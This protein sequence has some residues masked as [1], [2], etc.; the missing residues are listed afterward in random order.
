MLQQTQVD[1]VVPRWKRFMARFPDPAAA[2]SAGVAAVL[3]EWAGLG[4]NR[5]AVALHAAAVSCVEHHGGR[6]PDDL[7]GLR[8]L[9]G[10]GP[11]TARAVLAFA[12]HADVAVVDTNVGRVLAR[13]IGRRLKANEAQLLADASVPAGAGWEWNQAVLDFG[14]AVCSA[15]Q[16]QCSTCPLRR[17]C[18]WSGGP[19]DDPAR[20]SAGVTGGQ[21][22][23]EGSDRQ[24]RGRLVDALR[25]RAAIPQSE[26]AAVAGW[27]DDAERA[28]RV[29]SGLVND[30]LARRRRD[31]GIRRLG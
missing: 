10:V 21:S 17:W 24:G 12:H 22:R 14:A 16:P 7:D 26:L 18:S 25:T 15:R 2:A 9:P 19:G 8:S 4:Y 3:D 23:F 31:G 29:A 5:R 1:R 13:L 6:V 27:P 28:L 20:G 30:G 11:Y